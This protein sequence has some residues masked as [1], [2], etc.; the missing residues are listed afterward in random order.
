MGEMTKLYD[1]LV[2][3]GTMSPRMNREHEG[4]LPGRHE[5]CFIEDI[6]K[7]KYKILVVDDERLIRWSLTKALEGDDWEVV[8]AGSGEEALEKTKETDFNVLVT[9]LRLPGMDGV[10]LLKEVRLKNPECRVI[11]IS[12]YGTPR[13]AAEAKELGAIDFIDKPLLMDKMKELVRNSLEQ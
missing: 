4:F 11:V 7:N 8:S 5:N 13:L 9:D 1:A 6:M 2:F 12:G 3:M 10:D